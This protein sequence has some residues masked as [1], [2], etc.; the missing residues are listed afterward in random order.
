MLNIQSLEREKRTS[1]TL[2]CFFEIEKKK[3]E[4]SRNIRLSKQTA[5]SCDLTSNKQHQFEVMDHIFIRSRHHPV[6]SST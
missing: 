2:F 6:R 3:K 5:W 1:K 4:N